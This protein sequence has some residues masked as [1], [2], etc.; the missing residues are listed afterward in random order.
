MLHSSQ[1]LVNRAL[2]HVLGNTVTAVS[3]GEALATGSA[4]AAAVGRRA[5][6]TETLLQSAAAARRKESGKRMPCEK[7]LSFLS[8]HVFGLVV[9]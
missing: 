9:R 7:E 1:S 6:Q 3:A 5:E 2:S 8:T 4:A